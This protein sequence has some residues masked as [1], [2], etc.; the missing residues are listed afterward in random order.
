[1]GS[2]DAIVMVEGEAEEMTE[3]D[4]IEAINQLAE[5]QARTGMDRPTVIT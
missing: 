2:K 3:A 5:I 4:M 1:M